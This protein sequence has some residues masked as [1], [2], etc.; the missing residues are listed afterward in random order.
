MAKEMSLESVLADHIEE[1]N[2]I[3]CH[4]VEEL[5]VIARALDKINTSINIAGTH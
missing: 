2:R 1:Q 3:L 5:D 4:I